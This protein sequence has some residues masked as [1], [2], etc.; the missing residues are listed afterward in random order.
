MAAPNRRRFL[1]NCAWLAAGVTGGILL[2]RWLP[3]GEPALAQDDAAASPEERLRK[4]K[5]ELP[6]IG[7]PTGYVPAVRVDNLL[8]VS[9]YEPRKADGSPLVGKLG[10]DLDVKEGYQAARQI[11]LIML[12]AVRTE[13]GSLDKVVRLVKTFGMVNCMPNF[14]QTPQVI[15]GFNDLLAEVFGEKAGR[16]ARSA[17][18]M[19]S[20]PDGSVVEIEAI[21]QVKA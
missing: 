13:L 12:S 7:K 1:N 16:G 14:T 6:M 18:G 11:A 9:G 4:L 19:N 10:K 17:V 5:I 20:L 21:F 2:P 15:N 8:F 3:L